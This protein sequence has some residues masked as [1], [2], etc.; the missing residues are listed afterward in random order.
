MAKQKYVSFHEDRTELS[1]TW[2]NR[3]VDFILRLKRVFKLK[4]KTRPIEISLL[5]DV[6][7]VDFKKQKEQ[8][9]LKNAVHAYLLSKKLY[10]QNEFRD[11]Y[12]Y[13]HLSV[14]HLVKYIWV[15]SKYAYKD[16]YLEEMPVPLDKEGRDIEFSHDVGYSLRELIGQISDLVS[17]TRVREMFSPLANSKDLGSWADIRYSA[18]PE[19][20]SVQQKFKVAYKDLLRPAVGFSRDLRRSGVLK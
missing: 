1:L 5:C 11:A 14:E 9:Y 12:L 17:S 2:F 19:D 16:R 6:S 3:E 18:N 8:L 20:I 7:S 15:K 4:K 13:L 10:S